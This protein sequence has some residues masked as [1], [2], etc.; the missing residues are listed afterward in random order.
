MVRRRGD[1]PGSVPTGPAAGAAPGRSSASSPSSSSRSSLAGWLV[2][3]AAQPARGRRR[4]GVA[5]EIEPGWGT[6]EAGDALQYARRDRL[7]AR[8]PGVGEGLGRRFVPGRHLPAA[9]EHGR[10]RRARTRWRA[11][12]RPRPRA[13]A[14]TPSLALPPGL[15]LEQI[16]D[17]VGALPGHDRADVPRRSR[18]RAQSARSYQGDQPS[19]EGLTWPDTYFVEHQ[20]DAE[21]LH[22]IVAEFDEHADAVQPRRRALGRAHAVPGGRRGV[23]DPGRGGHRRRRAQRSPPS[24]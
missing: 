9:R 21:I 12:R 14:T 6:K 1:G 3:L 7:V 10:V 22:T 4:A 2:R 13:A 24:S 18:S 20:T 11:G 16:A 15:R 19:V 8:V 5:V 17:R 23:A